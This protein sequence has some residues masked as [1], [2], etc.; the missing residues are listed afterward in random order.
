VAAGVDRILVL[1]FHL[2]LL[3]ELAVGWL[4]RAASGIRA[5]HIELLLDDAG[6]AHCGCAWLCLYDSIYVSPCWRSVSLNGYRLIILILPWAGY[7]GPEEH[8]PR[9]HRWR[10]GCLVVP[11]RRPGPH[12]ERVCTR[13]HHIARVDLLR[14][15]DRS[16]SQDHSL[17]GQLSAGPQ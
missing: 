4:H 5:H 15:V 2:S 1:H 3:P 7:T 16:H 17:L 14:L 8:R 10:S 11:T 12:E 6:V 13:D 9:D